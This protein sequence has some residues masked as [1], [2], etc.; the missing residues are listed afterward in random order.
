MVSSILKVVS[1]GNELE[2]ARRQ[3]PITETQLLFLWSEAL[4]NNK[5]VD[6]RDDDNV[7]LAAVYPDY[8]KY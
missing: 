8:T 5:S 3:L 6:D 1:F 7:I 4:F 2:I